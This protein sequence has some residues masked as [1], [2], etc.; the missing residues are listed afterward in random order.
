MH[1]GIYQVPGTVVLIVLIVPA[2]HFLR[3]GVLQTDIT[4]ITGIAEGLSMC[5]YVCL[6]VSLYQQL[7]DGVS[8]ISI[9]SVLGTQSFSV[10]A[11]ANEQRCIHSCL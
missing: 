9:L 6:C 4:H 3:V 5:V 2:L 8:T 11:G 7:H 1:T 10:D